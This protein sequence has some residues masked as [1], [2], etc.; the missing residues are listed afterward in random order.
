MS[1]AA[2]AQNV[3]FKKSNFKDDVDGYKNATDAIDK[4]DEFFESANEALFNFQSEGDN[5]ENAL[6]HYKKAQEFNPDNGLLNFKIGVCYANSR[7]KSKCIPHFEKAYKLDKECDPF[8]NYYMGFMHQL[9]E[10]FKE[11]KTFYEK[12]ENDYR[13][14]DN[15]STFV[16]QRK[17]ECDFGKERK[18]APERVWVDNV[19]ELNTEFNDYSPTLTIDG[20]QLIFTSDRP[21]ENEA[22]E[23]GNY[24]NNIY[25]TVFNDGK[26][27][28]PLL[29]RGAVNTGDDVVSS[30]MSYTGDRLLVNKNE[31]DGIRHLYETTLSGSDW[32]TPQKFPSA[33]NPKS[34]SVTFAAY[35]PNYLKLYFTKNME[36]GKS[37]FDIYEA[38]S[39]GGGKYASPR[40]AGKRI[41]SKFHESSVYITPDGE[42][43]YICS[44]GFNSVG[45]YDIFVSKKVQGQW[46][47]PENMGYPINTPYDDM[48]FAITANGKYAYIAS[49]RDGGKGGLDIY[50]VTFWG[51]DKQL[52]VSTEDYM[53]AGISKPIGDPQI[54]E[55][56]EVNNVSLTVF[57]GKTIDALT[58]K[59]VQST[60]DII[61][62]EKG[63]VINSI[64]TNSASGKFLLTL[65]AGKNYGIA[66][67]ADGYLFHSEN[68]DVPKGSAYNLV[69]KTVE[70]KNI[71]VGSK[72]ALRNVFFDTGKS[73]L[74]S[75]SHTEL[76]RLVKLLKDVPSLKIEISGHTDN[77][78]SATL[79]EQLSQDRADAVVAYLKQKGI[80]AARLTSKGYG[81]SRPVASNN[82]EEG[83]QSNRRTEFE[84][85]A[86]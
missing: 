65:D 19:S 70:L 71:K 60:I 67:K 13:K 66:V 77:T 21:N 28:K 81:S 48:F 52:I 31:S 61:D 29:L 8:I 30:G 49:N 78:G 47:P 17:K 64:Q 51:P 82:S 23:F 85:L 22:D 79:N 43:M 59:P 63:D 76:D 62:N 6:F 56:V 4:G 68:F 15:F 86:N 25:T 55:T 73:D 3:E 38:Q 12:F 58:S 45:G 1:F 2:L 32:G 37:G 75:E 20:S 41:N 72:I 27:M 24:I 40:S 36:S 16:K 80:K 69:D 44:E 84:I 14:A 11:A 35:S 10:N 33:V 7:D 83:R 46:M 54:E 53:L 34:G 74:R 9:K 57:K 50:K 5:Y 26:W 39:L 42:T 18:A